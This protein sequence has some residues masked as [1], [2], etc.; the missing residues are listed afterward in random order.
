MDTIA[1]VA[2]N[3]VFVMDAWAKNLGAGAS[4]AACLV[5]VRGYGWSVPHTLQ[6]RPK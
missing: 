6:D 4:T 2:V 5:D 1:C 3:D